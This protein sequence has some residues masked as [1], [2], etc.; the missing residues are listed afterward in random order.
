[1]KRRDF[2]K[3]LSV[4]PATL[5]LGNRMLA[6]PPADAGAPVVKVRGDSP[7]RNTA[8]AVKMLGGMGRI[9]KKGQ[10]VMVKPNIGWNRNVEQAACTHPEVVRALVDL[11]FQAGAGKVIVMDHPCNT[12][13]RTYQRSG[14]E[15][16]ARKAG[17]EIRFPDENRLVLY[18][19][20]GENVQ[21]WPVYKDF[22]EVDTFI[23]V[24]ILK[25]HSSALLTIGMKNLYGILGGRRGKLHRNMGTGIADL[26]N[27]FKVDLTVVDATRIMLRN[28]PT[29]G[30]L[31]D[32]EKKDTVIASTNILEADVVATDLFG[33]DPL[34]IPFLVKGHEKG[35]GN[36]DLKKIDLRTAAA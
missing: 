13:E 20:K 36:I 28:G 7:Y 9:V 3:S 6:F 31:E 18:D 35:M 21:K 24:P 27:G 26:A 1:M 25:H 33:S 2:F 16:A 4:I 8:K 17:A 5:Y 19:F 34:Q 15:E 23:N 22:L 14:I 30:S 12:A 10:T 11:A 29:G 32:V